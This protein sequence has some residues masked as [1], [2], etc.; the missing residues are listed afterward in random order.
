MFAGK[1]VSGNRQDAKL[2]HKAPTPLEKTGHSQSDYSPDSGSVVAPCQG[3]RLEEE[4][5]VQ[6]ARR[7]EGSEEMKCL[8]V[9]RDN[10]SLGIE[11][12][13]KAFA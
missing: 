9:R 2:Q 8:K 3:Q 6:L 10:A 12:A 11:E 7:F 1:D 5:L 4:R 13:L